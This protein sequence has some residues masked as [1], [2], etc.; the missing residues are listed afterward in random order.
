[1]AET[2]HNTSLIDVYRGIMFFVGN[3]HFTM[4]TKSGLHMGEGEGREAKLL[5]PQ[6]PGYLKTKI[7]KLK[8]EN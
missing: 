2:F 7:L 5:Q 4:E 6:P 1:M 8:K 3:W